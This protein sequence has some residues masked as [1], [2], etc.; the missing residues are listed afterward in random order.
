MTFDEILTQI[1]ALLQRD[2]RVSYRALKRRFDPN[3][4]FSGAKSVLG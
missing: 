2:G 4:L 1:L 3:N